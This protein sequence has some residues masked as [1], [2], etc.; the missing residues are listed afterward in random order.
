MSLV[1]WSQY[2]FRLFPNMT[3]FNNTASLD[4]FLFFF[5]GDYVNALRAAREFSS[6]ISDSLKVLIIYALLIYI[7]GFLDA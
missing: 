5:Q 1:N 3:L 2:E 7:F 6:R 4:L